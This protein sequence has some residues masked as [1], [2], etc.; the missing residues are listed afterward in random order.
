MLYKTKT[1][2]TRLT[3]DEHARLLRIVAWLNAGDWEE[4]RKRKAIIDFKG[5]GRATTS[6]V[7]RFLINGGSTD[8]LHTRISKPRS[9]K[10]KRS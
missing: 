3:D 5:W 7:V 10:S 1:L 8:V 9:T 2:Q 4:Q 6:D